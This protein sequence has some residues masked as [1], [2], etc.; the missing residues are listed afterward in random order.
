MT[1]LMQSGI[2]LLTSE[3]H[4]SALSLRQRRNGDSALLHNFFG[5]AL[6]M[7]CINTSDGISTI[8]LFGCVTQPPRESAK[9]SNTS[10]AE[11]GTGR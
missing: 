3:M 2:A 11:T 4:F 5:A 10:S 8:S 1:L 7:N 9:T 6:A